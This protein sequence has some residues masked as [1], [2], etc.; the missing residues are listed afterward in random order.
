[1][2]TLSVIVITRNEE[3]NISACL[4]SV[5][6]AD[7]LIVVDAQ[8]TDR[9]VEIAREYTPHVHVKPWLGYSEAKELALSA[10]AG[11][12]VL[13]VDADE[14]VTP[15]LAEEIRE[16]VRLDDRSVAGYSVPR[17]AYFLGKWIRHCGWYPARVVRLFRKGSGTFSDALVHERLD[18]NGPVGR[19]HHDLLHFTDENLDHYFMKFNRYTS[20]AAEELFAKRRSF[21]LLDLL[22]RPPAFFFKMYV[23][24]LGFLDGIQGLILSVLS[25]CYVF[26]KYAKLWERWRRPAE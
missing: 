18:L 20:L 22:I 13:W 8:S 23:L 19:L 1:M 15:K 5:R 2:A 3:H 16:A 6:W 17:R 14:R 21:W 7:E 11:E 4:D 25:S 26:A 10:A 24:R 9:T 12:W